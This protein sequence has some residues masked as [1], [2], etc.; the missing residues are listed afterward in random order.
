MSKQPVFTEELSLEGVDEM[1]RFFS[2]AVARRSRAIDEMEQRV[3]NEM[4]EQLGMRRVKDEKEHRGR[5]KNKEKRE[6][7]NQPAIL[8]TQ[9]ASKWSL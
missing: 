2:E 4:E 5:E 8:Q 3:S 7:T 1:E 6:K 9:G